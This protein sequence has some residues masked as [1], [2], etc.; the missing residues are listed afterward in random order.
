[1]RIE[2]CGSSL[3]DAAEQPMNVAFLMQAVGAMYG[4]ERATLDLMSGLLKSGEHIHVLLIDEE[5]LGLEKSDLQDA[6]ASVG[7]PSTRLR[8]DR[9]FSPALA[10]RIREAA[11]IVGAQVVHTIGPKA[12][13]H[14]FFAIRNTDIRLVSTVHGWLFRRDPKER[15]YEWLEQKILKHFDRVIVLSSYYQN[16]LHETG[17]KPERVA[18][19]PSGL[20]AG[21][22]VSMDEAKRSLSAAHP[23]TVGTIGRFS[24]EKNLEMF[25]RSAKEIAARGGDIRFVMAGEGPERAKIEGL[26]HRFGLADVVRMPGYISVDQFMRQ[27]HVL[28][29][30]SLIENLPYSVMEAMAWCR[31]VVATAVGGLPDLVDEGKTGYL[32]PSND[33]EALAN[34]LREMSAWPR[35]VEEMGLGG[36]RKLE[37]EFGL[38][39][40]IERHRELY[41]E[42]AQG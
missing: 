17:F 30:C 15:F 9:A 3:Y 13:F 34:R 31:P 35:L 29:Q 21:S 14:G 37:T 12:T 18:R 1:L 42:L 25:L 10:R 32:V 11:G 38:A 20:D 7:I 5:R 19:I 28:V 2:H 23:F 40:Q 33:H 6:L 8:T 4:A 22:V 27:V 24:A 26:I 36:R 16:Y 41:S 39:R